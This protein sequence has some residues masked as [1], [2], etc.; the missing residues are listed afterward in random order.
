MSMTQRRYTAVSSVMI[1]ILKA[2]NKSEILALRR[3]A[4]PLSAALSHAGS[5][6][7]LY[8]SLIRVLWEFQWQKTHKL[9]KPFNERVH[10]KYT[11]AVVVK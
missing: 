2:K 1:L 6:E 4:Q 5:L 7:V 11:T 9:L 10:T 8:H 3:G